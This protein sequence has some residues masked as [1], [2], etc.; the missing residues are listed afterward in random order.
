MFKDTFR[1][2]R[3]AKG[4]LVDRMTNTLIID[5]FNVNYEIRIM[6]NS[7]QFILYLVSHA[8]RLSTFASRD[9]PDHNCF[10]QLFSHTSL[11]SFFLL[12]WN[13]SNTQITP[14]HNYTHI[15]PSIQTLC[16]FIPQYIIIYGNHYHICIC[17]IH[18]VRCIYFKFWIC[19]KCT[20]IVL[21]ISKW[22]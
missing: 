9:L 14:H 7:H 10:S 17:V 6:F 5:R 8:C 13:I 21:R 19:R 16:I 11:S 15:H 3:D 20:C 2:C 18:C 22:I 12:P 4:L 1:L